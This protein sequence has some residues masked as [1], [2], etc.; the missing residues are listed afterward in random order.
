MSQ[1]GGRWTFGPQPRSGFPAATG[2]GPSHMDMAVSGASFVRH[3]VSIQVHRCHRLGADPDVGDSRPGEDPRPDARP[4]FTGPPEF[5]N[6]V[7]YVAGGT[8]KCRP[9]TYET[10]AAKL[11]SSPINPP[12]CGVVRRTGSASRHASNNARLVRRLA[13]LSTLHLAPLP[14]YVT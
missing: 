13:V 9:A 4:A 2:N 8:P 6:R 7:S 12:S 14:R 10:S 11:A 3:M 5:S 1:E